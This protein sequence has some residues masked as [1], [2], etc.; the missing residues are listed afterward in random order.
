MTNAEFEK[1]RAQVWSYVRRG[2][3][4]PRKLLELRNACR[5]CGSKDHEP[6]P[7]L[8]PDAWLKAVPGGSGNLCRACCEK[9]LGRPLAPEDFVHERAAVH[10][11][12]T[13]S[14]H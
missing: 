11:R 3:R 4:I 13:H 14:R 2:R 12:A 6:L 10:E 9:R 7:M 1:L 8:K 5:D